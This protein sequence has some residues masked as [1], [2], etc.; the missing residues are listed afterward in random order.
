MMPL[1][2]F[3]KPISQLALLGLLGILFLD[4]CDQPKKTSR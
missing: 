2:C 1:T 4:G 3:R